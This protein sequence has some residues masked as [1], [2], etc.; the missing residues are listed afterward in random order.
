M[1][2][3]VETEMLSITMLRLGQSEPSLVQS[4]QADQLHAPSLHTMDQ[5]SVD[6]ENSTALAQVDQPCQAQSNSFGE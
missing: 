3:T 5:G 6:A 4:V 2:G 1:S